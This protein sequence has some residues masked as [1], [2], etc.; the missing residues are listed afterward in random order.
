MCWYL[1]CVGESYLN[2]YGCFSKGA[3]SFGK[4]MGCKGTEE[5]P[6]IYF[7]VGELDVITI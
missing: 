1:C 5:K 6:G 4:L 2:C 7:L 3:N